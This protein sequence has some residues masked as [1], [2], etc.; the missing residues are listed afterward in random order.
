MFLMFLS[1]ILGSEVPGGTKYVFVHTEAHAL[2]WLQLQVMTYDLPP[3]GW[4][5]Q[6]VSITI[7]TVSHHHLIMMPIL[8]QQGFFLSFEQH[9][10]SIL[11]ICP[12]ETSLSVIKLYLH[13][14]V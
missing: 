4:T 3:Q 5:N 12:I 13:F 10:S 14:H 8:W 9:L 11:K 1:A 6:L 2:Q 7:V